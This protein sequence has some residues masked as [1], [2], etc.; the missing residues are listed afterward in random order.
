MALF[1]GHEYVE[2][3]VNLDR[4]DDRCLYF[5]FQNR[6]RKDRERRQQQQQNMQVLSKTQ[7]S[8]ERLVLD[9]SFLC[10][11]FTQKGWYA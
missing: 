8:R 3:L 6:L 10:S 1:G 5:F 9:L 7:K 2:C 4:F 11:V